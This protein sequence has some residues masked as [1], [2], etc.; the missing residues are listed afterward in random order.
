MIMTKSSTENPRVRRKLYMGYADLLASSALI[1]WRTKLFEFVAPSSPMYLHQDIV[2]NCVPA[3]MSTIPSYDLVN[4]QWSIQTLVAGLPL[5][6]SMK[7]Q[8]LLS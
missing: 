3:F 5:L 8:S 6:R 7:S 4:V 2:T 1:C